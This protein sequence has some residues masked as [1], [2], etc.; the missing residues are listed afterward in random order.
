M[1]WKPKQP[2][3]K[4]KYGATRIVAKFIWW[5]K[6]AYIIHPTNGSW[7]A[8]T[9]WLETCKI[10]QTYAESDFNDFW[11]DDQWVDDEAS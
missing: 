10:H 7:N 3:W 11:R 8:E 1:R 5:P 9:R 6:T 2:P 4:P